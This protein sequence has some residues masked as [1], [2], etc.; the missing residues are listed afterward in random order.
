M[1]SVQDRKAELVARRA[2]LVER[3]G[4]VEHELESRNNPD[5]EDSATEREGDE[6]LER[7]GIDAGAEIVRI[8][9]ALS[10]IEAGEYGFCVKCGERILEERL[11]L[12]PWTPFCR[13]CAV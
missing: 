10:R 3:V 5:W 7:Q 2:E 12:L 13:H 4:E 1:K 8:D 11:D 6:V 9:A